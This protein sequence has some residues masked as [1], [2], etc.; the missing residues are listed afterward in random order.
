MKKRKVK[1]NYEKGKPKKRRK[2]DN[3]K[4]RKKKK[5]ESKA[6]CTTKERNSWQLIAVP[7]ACL[8]APAV[9]RPAASSTF[10][11]PFVSRSG[12]FAAERDSLAR[13]VLRGSFVTFLGSF[14]FCGCYCIVVVIVIIFLVLIAVVVIN[15]N[16]D[17]V[18][19][20]FFFFCRYY[21]SNSVFIVIPSQYWHDS[22]DVTII[23]IDLTAI[24]SKFWRV[25]I[26]SLI[27][28]AH[29]SIHEFPKRYFL[30]MFNIRWFRAFVLACERSL[31]YSCI[32]S[33]TR[34]FK[35]NFFIWWHSS[36]LSQG[37]E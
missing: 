8:C 18:V 10:A 35:I 2:K 7:V 21:C 36:L 22:M 16:A 12:D 13:F 27:C 6:D 9:P 14:C 34:T 11:F 30:N 17:F 5:V 15:A 32:Y 3:Q 23:M 4:E 29:E 31:I 19:F 24:S 33:R 20:I 25:I 28:F 1:E 37:G 26:G